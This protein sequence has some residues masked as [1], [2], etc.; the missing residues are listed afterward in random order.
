METMEPRAWRRFPRILALD[1]D[2]LLSESIVDDGAA[3][4]LELLHRVVVEECFSLANQSKN[5]KLP[6]IRCFLAF[7]HHIDNCIAGKNRRWPLQPEYS[8]P[9]R[10]RISCHRLDRRS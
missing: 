8:T 10:W 2:C 1:R 3:A 9:L 6:G 5:S 4:I 7:N